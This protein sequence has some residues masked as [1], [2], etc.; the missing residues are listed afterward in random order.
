MTLKESRTTIPRTL[1][2]VREEA[3]KN[4]QG[5]WPGFE[6]GAKNFIASVDFISWTQGRTSRVA[7]EFLVFGQPIKLGLAFFRRVDTALVSSNTHRISDGEV[8]FTFQQISGERSLPLPHHIHRVS[9]ILSIKKD[10]PF[11]S[12]IEFRHKAGEGNK[13][14]L[15]S[16]FEVER[17]VLVRARQ[18]VMP[19]IYE[20]ALG[21]R[22]AF[23]FRNSEGLVGIL[24]KDGS[25]IPP[26]RS[27][28]AVPKI[29]A[30]LRNITQFRPAL[31]ASR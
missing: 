24:H 27:E 4:L 23:V 1:E 29:A 10:A 15:R 11:L 30:C 6:Q 8:E 16:R 19:D 7:A 25:M 2:E 18:D 5:F 12:V 17:G 31:G 28:N 22:Q 13:F 20:Y 3:F 9:L 14:L 26:M 21:K